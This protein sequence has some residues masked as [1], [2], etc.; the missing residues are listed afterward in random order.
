MKAY[1]E[2]LKREKEKKAK[3]DYSALLTKKLTADDLIS[4]WNNQEVNP[5]YRLGIGQSRGS[6]MP[7]MRL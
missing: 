2:Q 6:S 4:F 5:H 7:G 1:Q 3:R